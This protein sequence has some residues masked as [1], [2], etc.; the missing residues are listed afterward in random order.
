MDYQNLFLFI[1]VVEKGS[2]VAAAEELEVPT[3]TLSRRVQQLEQQLGYQLLYRSARRLSLSEAGKLFYQRCQPLVEG[4][5]DA[6]EQLSGELTTPTGRLK[7]TAPISLANNLLNPWLFEFLQLHPAIH[8]D[9]IVSNSNLDLK[10]EGVDLAFRIGEIRIPDWISR[11]L[12]TSR[13]ILCAAPSLLS[14]S[15]PQKLEDLDRFPLLISRR[16]PSWSFTD[17][18]GREWD[19]QGH[20]HLS[21]DE[22]NAA[23]DAAIMGVGIANLP[24]Y[25]AGPAVEEGRLMQILTQ[26]TPRGR[27]V[28]MV[29][30][31]RQ[32]LPAKVRLLIE[33]VLNKT[34]AL[35]MTRQRD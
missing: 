2:F 32:H 34:A 18:N 1:K 5:V 8:L 30:P 15:Q 20:P 23:L 6:T 4:L 7:V 17:T 11:P 22:L 24:D 28:H 10:E 33:F 19:Y 16:L 13:F 25:V 21:Y 3:S 35:T 26:Y 9:L 29:Y 12:F 27:A 31:H 14:Q